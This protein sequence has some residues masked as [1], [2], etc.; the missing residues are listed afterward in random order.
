MM[1]RSICTSF[2]SKYVGLSCI[3]SKGQHIARALL[4]F[5]IEKKYLWCAI[6]TWWTSLDWRDAHRLPQQRCALCRRNYMSDHVSR[7]VH[8]V[9]VSI[10]L[11]ILCNQPR[12]YGWVYGIYSRVLLQTIERVGFGRK[13]YFRRRPR[14]HGRPTFSRLVTRRNQMRTES[15]WM[16]C[17]HPEWLKV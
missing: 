3:E 9:P 10:I 2:V 11:Y 16:S 5:R 15:M 13:R 7:R 8:I 6:W 4:K 17:H 12:C 1:C 14:R